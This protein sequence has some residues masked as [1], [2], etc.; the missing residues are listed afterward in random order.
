METKDS[1]E[2]EWTTHR[3]REVRDASGRSRGS[4]EPYLKCCVGEGPVDKNLLK[5]RDIIPL[6]TL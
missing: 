2:K 4:K 1:K 3:S 5:P 6:V